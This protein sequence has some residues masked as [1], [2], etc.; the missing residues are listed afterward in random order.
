MPTPFAHSLWGLLF[1]RGSTRH[2]GSTPTLTVCFIVWMSSLP[3]YDYLL[4]LFQP[5][6]T[7]VHR[8]F[9]HSVFFVLATAVLVGAIAKLGRG[10]F[11]RLFLLAF[12]LGNLHLL[13]DVLAVDTNPANGIGLPLLQPLSSRLF[14]F[15]LGPFV[16]FAGLDPTGFQSLLIDEGF[17]VVMCAGVLGILKLVRPRVGRGRR[18]VCESGS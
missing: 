18:L 14:S 3:D 11:T 13:L 10:R 12:A 4:A 9:S 17:F 7:A 8:A 2:L 5:G 16:G 6:L 15:P 1:Y